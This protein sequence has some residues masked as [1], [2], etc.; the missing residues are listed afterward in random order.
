MAT[1]TLETQ[2]EQRKAAKRATFDTLKG[3]KRTEREFEIE[4]NGERVSF[5]FRSIGATAYDKLLTRFPPTREQQADGATYDQD[6][7]APALLSQVSVEPTLTE[8]EWREIWTSD[9]WNRG[10]VG[11]L[12]W[13]AVELCNKG[14]ELNPTEAG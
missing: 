8:E 14:L 11:I 2:N 1:K 10:E 7:F 6:R 4:L 5:L 3:K 9:E 12:F 13:T